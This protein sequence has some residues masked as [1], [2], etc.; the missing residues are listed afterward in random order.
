MPNFLCAV[1]CFNRFWQGLGDK[2]LPRDLNHSSKFAKEPTGLAFSCQAKPKFHCSKTWDSGWSCH[3]LL[4]LPPPPTIYA[5]AW[6]LWRTFSHSIL[7]PNTS[8]TH[9]SNDNTS[10]SPGSPAQETEGSCFSVSIVTECLIQA[11][12]L[13]LPPPSARLSLPLSLRTLEILHNYYQA[14][15]WSSYSPLAA[16]ILIGTFRSTNIDKAGEIESTQLS[17]TTFPVL[18]VP[19]IF[20]LLKGLLLFLRSRKRLPCHRS[21]SANPSHTP[22]CFPPPHSFCLHCY[23]HSLLWELRCCMQSLLHSWRC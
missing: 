3:A 5:C 15:S 9:T 8:T 16:H 2:R 14:K 4:L 19:L 21:V 13:S 1:S 20:A 11:L 18:S 17:I 7:F 23:T 6:T 10:H 22:S 12:S